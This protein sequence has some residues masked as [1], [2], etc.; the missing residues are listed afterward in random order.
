MKDLIFNVNYVQE[1]ENLVRDKNIEYIDAIVHYCEKSG[2]EIEFL[3]GIIK[4]DPVMK[5][6]L[7]FE[8]E[9]LN[10]MKKSARL[11]I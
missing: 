6:K 7:Q 11:P 2:L 3:A 1:I 5:S 8:A 9:N 10:F 4:K